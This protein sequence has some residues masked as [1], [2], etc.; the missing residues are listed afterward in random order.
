MNPR[1]R[2]RT[3]QTTAAAARAKV[4]AARQALADELETTPEEE[5]MH[6]YPHPIPLPCACPCPDREQDRQCRYLTQV[7]EELQS[8]SQ[9]LADLTQAVNGLTAALLASR[10]PASE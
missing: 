7:L 6:R 2:N 8:Q 5:P 3:Y 4:L 10:S 9:L 1:Q